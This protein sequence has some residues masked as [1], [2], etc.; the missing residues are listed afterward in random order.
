MK[1]I[2]AE[3]TFAG[4]TSAGAKNFRNNFC[5]A[6]SRELV[7]EATAESRER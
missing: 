4:F 7:A 5:R 1:S 2:W 3:S 6:D